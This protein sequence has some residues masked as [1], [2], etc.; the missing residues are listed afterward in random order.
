MLLNKYRILV[1]D[2]EANNRKLLLQILKDNYALAFAVNGKQAIEVAQKIKPDLIL[3]DIM[4][5]GMDGYEVCRKIKS[6]P[7]IYNIPII[8][9]TAM[10]EIEDETRGF[11]AGCVDY[12][13]K[14]ISKSLVLARVAT[15]IMLYNQH[16]E[17]E[18]EVIRRTAMFQESQ[19]SAIHML[20]EAG[21]YNDDDT[22]CHIWRIGAYA[23]AIARASGWLVDKA[24]ELNLAAAMHDTG[25]IGIPDSVL[26]KPGKLDKEEWNVM[27]THTTIGYDILSKSDTPF[28]HLSAQI[29]LSHHEKWNGSG[30]PNG[31]NGKNIPQAARIVAICDVFDALTMKR[32]YKPAWSVEDSFAEIEKNIGTHFDPEL[33]ECFMRIQPEIIEIKKSWEN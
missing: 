13:T 29:A 24:S 9:T 33:A 28:F 32:S 16:K 2:D 17:C 12:I 6:D 19:K 1:V 3:L 15:H 27:K 14:P 11:E 26:K 5:P 10:N 23:V 31:L 20:G 7:E 21:H 18:A 30:Y 8:F 22:G 25:K 4:M